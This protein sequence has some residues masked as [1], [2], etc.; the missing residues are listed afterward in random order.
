[1]QHRHRICSLYTTPVNGGRDPCINSDLYWLQS[2]DNGRVAPV[3][4]AATTPPESTVELQLTPRDKNSVDAVLLVNTNAEDTGD[5]KLSF[6]VPKSPEWTEVPIKT[7]TPIKTSVSLAAESKQR[8]EEA[9]KEMVSIIPSHAHGEPFQTGPKQEL[10]AHLTLKLVSGSRQADVAP[11]EAKKHPT[12]EQ[13]TAE[14]TTSAVVERKLTCVAPRIVQEGLPKLAQVR[15][16]SIDAKTPEAT[17]DEHVSGVTKTAES[18]SPVN[19]AGTAQATPFGLGSY[20]DIPVGQDISSS[21][22]WVVFLDVR[23]ADP[24]LFQMFWKPLV[25]F[26][27]RH[28]LSCIVGLS[29]NGGILRAAFCDKRYLQ[30]IFFP[31]DDSPGF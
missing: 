19:V 1:V 6:T 15:L 16:R 24:V 22:T 20:L 25:I 26:F 12:G 23:L 18:S 29:W 27:S 30:A 17:Q 11:D 3:Q 13:S 2:D 14:E 5:E 28:A 4:G 31:F 8:S 7:I 21:G 9:G 10:S